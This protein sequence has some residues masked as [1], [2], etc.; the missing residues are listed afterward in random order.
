VEK[1]L[2]KKKSKRG[3]QERKGA[4][5]APYQEREGKVQKGSLPD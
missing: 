4:R 3:L 5:I 1:E 2:K